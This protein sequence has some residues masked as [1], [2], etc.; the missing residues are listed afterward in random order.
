[1]K[2]LSSLKMGQKV[3]A[4]FLMMIAITAFIGYLGIRNLRAIDK[5]DTELYQINTVPLGLIGQA[6]I[7]FNR[8]RVNLRD[9]ILNNEDLARV[10]EIEELNAGLEKTYLENLKVFGETIRSKEIRDTYDDVSARN[11]EYRKIQEQIIALAKAHQTGKAKALMEGDGFTAARAIN[12]GVDKLVEL[13][14]KDAQAKSDDN[15]QTAAD[16]VR[17]TI[18]LLIAC[19]IVGIG[20]TLLIMRNVSG[21]ITGLLDETGRLAQAAA[22]GELTA[23]GD[24]ERVNHEFRGIIVG[25]NGIFDPFEETVVRIQEMVKQVTEA[26]QQMAQVAEN[27][28]R[29]SQEVAGGAQQVAEGATVQTKSASE[30][31]ENMEQLRRAIEEVARG[32]QVGAQGAEQAATATQQA[33]Q[34]IK[35]IAEAAEAARRD[36]E[37]TGDVARQGA[38]TV[39]ETVA[40][41]ARV[42]QAS[43]DSSEKIFALG[44]ASQKIGE[45]V[46]AI[47]DIAEQ[48]NLLAL[49]AA[50]EAARAGE[51]GKGFAVVADEVRKLAE[52]SASQTREIALLIRNIQEGIQTAVDSMTVASREVEDGVE[53]VNNAGTALSDILNAT[54]NV[55]AQVK[56]VSQLCEEVE[57]SSNEV[58]KVVDSVSTS[59]EQSNAATEQMTASST[60]VMR[61]VEQFTAGIEESSSVAEELSAAAQEQN[62]SVEEM[63]AST[64]NL[65]ELSRQTKQMLDRFTVDYESYAENQKLVPTGPV[66]STRASR[67]RALTAKS[68]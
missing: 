62:A 14:T 23:R 3:L 60:E 15:T 2:W 45:I 22:D 34:A 13:K 36:A 37:N 57:K 12:E 49:N 44:E 24:P 64:T 38:T 63:T 18:I 29:A 25:V 5:K 9:I 56:S 55:V 40:G 67:S 66:A 16:A 33:V 61:V 59:S 42:K 28:G 30:V 58:F 17:N 21:I 10:K 20:F 43:A 65:A 32:V 50:I 7:A 31:T 51:H 6:S 54:D 1:M 47:N 11:E 35:Q 26:S 52:R 27:V 39:Q 48:T 8:T 41:M 46:E 4:G 68:A 53:K 19:V